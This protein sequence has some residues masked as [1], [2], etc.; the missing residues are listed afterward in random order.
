MGLARLPADVAAAL[1]ASAAALAE[2]VAQLDAV[3]AGADDG[4]LQAVGERRAA[5]GD[6]MTALLAATGSSLRAGP[7]R[8]RLAAVARS[9]DRGS[10][11]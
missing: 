9:T 1:G 6:A 8:A 3:L 7:D 11:S 10:P 2:C 5:C 4:A